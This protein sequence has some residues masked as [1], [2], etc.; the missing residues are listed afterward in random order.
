MR[1][2]FVL[3]A[4]LFLLTAA[5]A[6]PV[7]ASSIDFHRA[8]Y[9]QFQ[10]DWIQ[11]DRMRN[12]DQWE[13]QNPN[14]PFGN[15]HVGFVFT[16]EV[17]AGVMEVFGQIADLDC[18]VGVLPPSGGHGVADVEPEPEPE[19]PCT[20]LGV[21]QIQGSVPFTVGSK[22]TTATLGGPGITVGIFGGGDPHGGGGDLLANVPINVQFAGEGSLAR[23]TFSSRWTDGTYTYSSRYR[24]IS[25]PAEL[26][27]V[28]GPMGF[29]PE[30]SG[31]F[32]SYNKESYR[33]RSR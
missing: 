4:T 15:V 3:L 22:L 23:G 20:H 6:Q 18:P 14:R 16:F 27:G 32:M 5:L 28:L 10:F 24:S 2:T 17:T 33:S 7:S 13:P 25:R 30:L 19:N 26:T 11:L 1:R 12:G 8:S 21:R 29:D 31:G 9:H